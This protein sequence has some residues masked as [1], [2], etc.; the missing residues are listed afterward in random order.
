[1]ALGAQR[2]G[3][4]ALV[5]NQ[6]LILAFIG[7]TI[8]IGGAM[9]LVGIVKNRLF[10]VTTTDPLNLIVTI[11]LLLGVTLMACCLPAWRASKVDPAVALR[12]E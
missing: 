1:M 10:G 12:A 5:L 11:G 4:L 3:V 9:V 2:S 8:G 6:G 7:C